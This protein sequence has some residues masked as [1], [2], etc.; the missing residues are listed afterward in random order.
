MTEQ[1]NPIKQIIAQA[2]NQGMALEAKDVRALR[3]RSKKAILLFKS[4]FWAGIV[5]FN[6][7][8]WAPLPIEINRSLLYLIALVSMV[9]AIVVPIIGLKKHQ[10]NLELL[11]VASQQPKKKTAN[12]KG[13]TYI[14]Q[15]R[16]QDRP[17]VNAEYE[18]LEGSKW[19]ASEEKPVR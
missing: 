2:I 4:V 15:V 13:R 10:M 18:L 3:A 19:A 16:Q 1:S 11:R 8:L 14:D 9:V 17:F 6:L 7:V 12:D 5:I